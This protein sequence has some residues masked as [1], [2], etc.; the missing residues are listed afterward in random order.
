MVQNFAHSSGL[1]LNVEKCEVHAY[2]I[3]QCS[4]SVMTNNIMGRI[5]VQ[6]SEVPVIIPWILVVMC[7]ISAQKRIKEKL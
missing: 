6:V 7:D 2:I 4:N 1:S 5:F 3:H